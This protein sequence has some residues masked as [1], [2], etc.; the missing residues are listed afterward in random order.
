MVATARILAVHYS[1]NERF[2][3]QSSGD[4]AHADAATRSG[5]LGRNWLLYQ[6]TGFHGGS[7]QLVTQFYLADREFLCVLGVSAVNLFLHGRLHG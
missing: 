3:P 1:D 6:G 7:A 5:G 4:A 2:F